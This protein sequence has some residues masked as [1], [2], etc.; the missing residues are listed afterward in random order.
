[1]SSTPQVV[2][3]LI[4]LVAYITKKEEVPIAELASVFGLSESTVRDYLDVLLVSGMP[5]DYGAKIDVWETD[6]I[7]SLSNTGRG[8]SGSSVQSGS[9]PFAHGVRVRRFGHPRGRPDCH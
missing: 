7:V 3:T 4:S 9:A 2:T 6:G 1:M 5:D 8:C